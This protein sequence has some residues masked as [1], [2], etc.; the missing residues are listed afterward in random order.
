[1]VDDREKGMVGMKQ[2][3]SYTIEEVAQL[4]R[5]SKLTVYDLIKKDN[6]PAY[7]VGRQMRV[8]PRDLE[9]YKNKSK[10]GLEDTG[11]PHSTADEPT[12]KNQ[13]VISGQDVVLDML[14]KYIDKHTSLTP[15]RLYSGSLNSLVSMYNGECDVVSLHLY[16]GDTE[17]YNLPYVKRI[18][19]NQPFIMIH[20]VQRTAGFYVQQGNPKNIQTWQ[21]LAR[22]N[23]TFINREKGSGAR[24]LLDEQLRMKQV[25]KASIKGYD[26]ELTSHFA[27]A[28]AVAEGQA[29]VGV[30]IE[31]AAKMVHVDFIPLMQEQ[32]DLVLLKKNENASLIN[33]IKEA[34]A[35]SDYLSQL[36]Q[37]H[38]YDIR[39]TG[40]VLYESPS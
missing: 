16:D 40:K 21:D 13:I 2:S 30:G 3:S 24:V 9:N 32:Y 8:D 12:A 39:F 1:M 11:N 14:S 38:G 15:L 4:L 5:V 28:S 20:L 17:E 25:S 37:L 26:Q 31:Q 6:L 33:I 18:L 35:S 22:P 10:T 36:K 7:R 29:D 34:L 19:V 23:V 27:V